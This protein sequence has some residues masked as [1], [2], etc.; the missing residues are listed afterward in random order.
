MEAL[1]LA[2][3]ACFRAVNER[4]HIAFRF[5]CA[6]VSLH[7]FVWHF[8][9]ATSARL[10]NENGRLARARSAH[11]RSCLVALRTEHHVFAML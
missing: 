5:A 8:F 10:M 4:H 2:N 11:S 6:T 9:A 1:H 7:D 3:D